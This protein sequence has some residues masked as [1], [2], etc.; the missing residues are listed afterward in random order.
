[1]EEHARVSD[2]VLCVVEGHL[3]VL[4]GHEALSALFD[5]EELEGDERGGILKWDEFICLAFKARGGDSYIVI[6]NDSCF[7]SGG[8]GVEIICQTVI[9]LPLS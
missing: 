7:F 6:C 1:M 4:G 9:L 2:A 3:E 5:L 8:G